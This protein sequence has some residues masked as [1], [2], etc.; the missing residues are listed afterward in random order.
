MLLVKPP[1]SSFLPKQNNKH[2]PFVQPHTLPLRVGVSSLSLFPSAAKTLAP[3]KPR[4]PIAAAAAA[5]PL[6]RPPVWA[7]PPPARPKNRVPPPPPPRWT[8]TRGSASPRTPGCRVRASVGP[9][10]SVSILRAE[11]RWWLFFFIFFLF[12]GVCVCGV[13]DFV[14][15]WQMR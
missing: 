3:P 4:R 9:K 10:D 1:S 6:S 12:F 13:F 8:W 14:V 2:L 7:P 5:L 11:F 15:W